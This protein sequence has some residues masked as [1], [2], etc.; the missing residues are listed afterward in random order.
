MD[1]NGGVQFMNSC[2]ESEL[3]KDAKINLKPMVTEFERQ[4]NTLRIYTLLKAN[5]TNL[6]SNMFS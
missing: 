3:F 2:N 1:Y 5:I 4:K 6:I